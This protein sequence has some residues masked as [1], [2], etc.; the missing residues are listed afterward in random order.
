LCGGR[1]GDG[2]K[3]K[4]I[5]KE[6]ESDVVAGHNRSRDLVQKLVKYRDQHQTWTFIAN[7]DLEQ[8]CFKW[9]V[10]ADVIVGVDMTLSVVSLET[11]SFK[12]NLIEVV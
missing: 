8:V 7:V 4:R 11:P 2:K 1:F 9:E 6:H 3:F 5:P 10:V 12:C